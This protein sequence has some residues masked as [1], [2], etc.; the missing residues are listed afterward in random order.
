[1]INKLFLW[2]RGYKRIDQIKG[3][4]SLSHADI[5]GKLILFAEYSVYDIYYNERRDWY[6][7]T[8]SG[9]NPTNHTLHR[10]LLMTLEFLNYKPKNPYYVFSENMSDYFIQ[11]DEIINSMNYDFSDV[12]EVGQTEDTELVILRFELTNDKSYILKMKDNTPDKVK[13]IQAYKQTL[14]KKEGLEIYEEVDNI[15]ITSEGY[16]VCTHKGILTQNMPD[17]KDEK[18]R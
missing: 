12:N 9:F 1:M 15:L 18:D 17:D 13:A 2:I 5:S 6:K 7:M 4:W 10:E 11:R 3:L 14:L 16:Y 8:K